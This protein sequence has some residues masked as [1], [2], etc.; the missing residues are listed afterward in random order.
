MRGVNDLLSTVNLI[1]FPN[2]FNHIGLG[3][4]FVEI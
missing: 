3:L 4:K 1:A 2:I